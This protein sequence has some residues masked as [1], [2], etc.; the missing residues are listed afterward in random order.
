MGP[1][2]PEPILTTA[3]GPGPSAVEGP[4]VTLQRSESVTLAFLV[5]LET[6]APEERAVFILREVFDYSHDEI[7]E[8]LE[9]TPANCRQ[10]LHRAKGKIKN[11]P[12]HPEAARSRRE[13]LGRFADALKIRRCAANSPRCSRRMS[14]SGATAGGRSRPPGVRSPAAPRC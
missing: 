14:G 2:L 11:R 4:D 10:L 1:W 3:A 8:V 13:V 7:A 5:L 9:L 12:V 6:L